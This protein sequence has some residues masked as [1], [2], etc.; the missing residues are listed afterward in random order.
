MD[1]D[2]NLLFGVLA[3]QAGLIDSR[4]FNEACKLSP[5]EPG[6]TLE[7]VLLARGW[8]EPADQPHLNYLVER[9]LRRHQGNA[10]ATLAAFPRILRQSLVALEGFDSDHTVAG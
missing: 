1:K 8:I 3:L 10:K 7:A 9:A 5:G 4:Q 2:R 6:G